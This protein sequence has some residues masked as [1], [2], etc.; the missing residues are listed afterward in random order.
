MQE[1]GNDGDCGGSPGIRWVTMVVLWL[2]VC[3]CDM[4]EHSCVMMLICQILLD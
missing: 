1:C 2:L 4:G 3:W